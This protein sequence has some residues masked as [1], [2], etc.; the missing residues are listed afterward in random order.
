MAPA[1]QTL[2]KLDDLATAGFLPAGAVGPLRPV[3][4]RYAIALPPALA[5]LIDKADPAD[6]IARQFVPDAR[7]LET[8]PGDDPDPIG[9]HLKSPVKGLVH[10]YPDRVLLKPIAACAVYCRFCFRREMVGPGGEAM[11]EAD[12]DA[13]LAYIAARPAIWEA[14]LTGGDPLYQSNRR[15]AQTTAR[16]AGIG[17]VKVLRWHTR[18][19]VAAPER[20]NAAMAKALTHGHEK[21]V[22]VA[23]H[24]N[25]PRELT[26][27]ARAAIARLRRA[28]I[29][30]ISQS[31]LLKGVNDEVSTLES[32][33]RGFVE[34][35]VKPYYLHHADR[36]P[37]TA[38]LRTTVAEGQALIGALR[39]RLSGLAMPTYV[40]DLPGAHGK[41]H[42]APGMVHGVGQGDYR[43]RDRHGVEHDYADVMEAK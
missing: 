8:I 42:L 2:R 11:S 21:S 14:I 17:H 34:A 40:L 36:A 41:A 12:W 13:A 29:M 18:L 3:A 5:A 16:L 38:H 4:A 19:P 6:P 43:V 39:E 37:G 9:D 1:A 20:V 28:G 25:H 22:V 30:L 15:I 31:V 24:A 27:D 33:M 10:R 23:V 32:L 26:L 35:G 7:E